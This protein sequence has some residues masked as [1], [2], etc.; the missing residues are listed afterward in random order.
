MHLLSTEE[1]N[2]LNPRST[3]TWPDL[4]PRFACAAGHR[5]L[6]PLRMH[7]LCKLSSDRAC[8][9]RR[10]KLCAT[11]SADGVNPHFA[12]NNTCRICSFC[13]LGGLLPI[14]NLVEVYYGK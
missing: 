9:K 5:P 8:T 2:K 4:L 13:S 10:S 3:T 7:R 6:R 12:H 1:S 14:V 11:K